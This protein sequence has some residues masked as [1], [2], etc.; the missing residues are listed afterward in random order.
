MLLR[1][2]RTIKIK[3]ELQDGEKMPTKKRINCPRDPERNKN[4]TKVLLS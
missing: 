2:K 3:H 4:Y 1:N